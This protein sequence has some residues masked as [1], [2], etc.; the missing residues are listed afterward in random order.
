MESLPARHPTQR[1]SSP[2]PTESAST[3]SQTHS[4][5]SP[6]RSRSEDSQTIFIQKDDGDEED[7]EEQPHQLLEEPSQILPQS[8]PQSQEIPKCWICLLDATEDT[9]DSTPWR[10][11]CPCALV[12]HEACLLDWIADMESPT[13]SSTTSS[14]PKILCPQCKSPILLSRPRDLLVSA[15]QA[16][17]RGIAYTFPK[18][19]LLVL[20]G[21]IYGAC[22]AGGIHTIYAVF[23]PDEGRRILDP[24]MR[25]MVR[26]PVDAFVGRPR[27][28]MDRV[29]G[30][31]MEHLVH[32]RLYVGLPLI[33]PTLILS[34][35]SLADGV[36]PILPVL[37]FV[38]QKGVEGGELFQWPPSAEFA[39][40]VLPYVRGMYNAW[41]KKFWE[42]RKK[43]WLEELQ[44]RVQ[45]ENEAAQ[46][47]LA[48]QNQ[49]PAQVA[50]E[51]EGENVVEI[52]VDGGFF[53]NGDDEEE[54][55]P[56]LVPEQP[57]NENNDNE[58]PVQ[59][60]DEDNR[61]AARLQEAGVQPEDLLEAAAAAAAAAPQIPD[62]RQPAA[63]GA[64]NQ[65][66]PPNRNEVL[67]FSPTGIAQTVLGALA[68]PTLAGLAGESLKLILPTSWLRGKVGGQR[69]FLQA[70]WAR[71]LV[72]GCLLVIGKDA[73]V[74]YVRWR[75]ARMQ[76]E[77]K[78]LDFKGEG[79]RGATGR[80]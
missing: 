21:V 64:G 17:E 34:R 31:V 18:A 79:A 13:K 23:G 71:T 10:S 28:A 59:M 9:P 37:F 41:Y 63:A 74:L 43:G 6:I 20:G 56:N 53:D 26:A 55:L 67:S 57:I 35:T 30:E 77:R 27:E 52:R 58:Q 45:M 65:N 22:A 70:K 68:F 24:V 29:L 73:L 42:K 78:V 62:N 38:T 8:S 1:R 39:F 75:M 61:Q 51:E 12:A 7:Q 44:P 40:A 19:S 16:A 36:L 11:P 5:T 54:E 69:T 25:N 4:T 66:R 76:R 3:T 32:W 49:G 47:G 46:E 33:T 2:T 72:G 14:K 60:D 50:E 15:F 48:A 80:V